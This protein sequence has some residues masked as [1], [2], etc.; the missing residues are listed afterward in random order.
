MPYLHRPLHV[1][2]LLAE[3]H[4]Q[5]AASAEALDRV[6]HG[7]LVL[8]A[9]GRL[10]FANRAGQAILT[11]CDGLTF[12]GNRLRSTRPQDTATLAAAIAEAVRSTQG[13][14]LGSAAVVTLGRPSGR[15]PLVVAVSPVAA[16]PVLLDI[17][18]PAAVVFVT[19]P[20]RAVLPDEA[21][22]RQALGLTPAE[23]RLARLLAEGID[24]DQAAARLRLT[25]HTARSRLKAIF[26]K[27][28]THRQVELVRLV[29]TSTSGAQM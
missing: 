20:D 21:L 27:T 8:S 10:L 15:R 9:A 11:S 22:I 2:R 5:L 12:E 23:A 28:G 26:H 18:R 3:A 24:L 6:A 7:V 25:I 14:G 1:D 13:E 17:D 29:L 16:R 19:D 4:V